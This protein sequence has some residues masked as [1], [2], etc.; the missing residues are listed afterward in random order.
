MKPALSFEKWGNRGRREFSFI[1]NKKNKKIEEPS[2]SYFFFNLFIYLFYFIFPES[3]PETC[4]TWHI[5]YVRNHAKF[6]N[7][8]S[9]EAR[10]PYDLTH[11]GGWGTHSKDVYMPT[12]LYEGRLKSL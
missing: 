12:H 7:G 6:L 1:F 11:V 5:V 10:N 8:H 4:F 2:S 3:G 9:C